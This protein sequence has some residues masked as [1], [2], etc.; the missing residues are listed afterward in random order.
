MTEGPLAP[1]IPNTS[2]ECRADGLK[3]LHPSRQ[4]SLDMTTLF[5][6][7]ESVLNEKC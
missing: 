6:S 4:T 7:I 5:Y 1:E 2:T 3:H